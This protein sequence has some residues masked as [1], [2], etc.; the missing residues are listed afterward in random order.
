[1][2]YSLGTDSVVNQITKKLYTTSF[3][4]YNSILCIFIC[5][6]SFCSFCLCF[7]VLLQSTSLPSDKDQLY[8]MRHHTE[9]IPF[10]FT[11]KTEQTSLQNAAHMFIQKMENVQENIAVTVL[12]STVTS[13]RHYTVMFNINVVLLSTAVAMR[14]CLNIRYRCTN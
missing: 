5:S 7:H 1:M 10:T 12:K 13:K 9:Y 6:L 11:C 8:V 4:S 2:I 3:T 14:N